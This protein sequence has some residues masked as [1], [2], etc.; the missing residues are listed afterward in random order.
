MVKCDIRKKITILGSTGSIGTQTLDIIND[1]S[2]RFECYAL[3][4]RS[5]WQ[6][7]AQQ[8]RKF[9]PKFVVIE[10]A[11]AFVYLKEELKDLPVE[12]MQGAE[13]IAEVAGLQDADIVV[14]ALVGYSGLLPTINAIN[15]GKR[16]AL[17][18]KETL[19]VGGELITSLLRNSKS[20][21]IPVDSE[22]SAIFQCLVG[23]DR[24][25]MHKIILTASGGPFRKLSANELEKVT[26]KDA[27]AHPNWNMG[28]KVTIDSASMMNK[29]FE[30]IEACWLFDCK[31]D[32]IEVVVHPQS[33]VH[34]MVEFCD[35]SIKAQ[36]GITDMHLPIRYALSYPE[37][38]E[39]SSDYLDITKIGTL[40][41]EK[42][43]YNKF[44][45]LK[46]AFQCMAA[47]G[48]APCILNAANE[49]AVE[50][51]LNS[52]IKF[53]DMPKVAEKVLE[54]MNVVSDCTLEHLV[55]TNAEARKKAVDI[56]NSIS[57]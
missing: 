1:Y 46:M 54:K 13:K 5:N 56:I 33:I 34:S 19:V 3:T 50:A 43:D 20:E 21:I 39:A 16:I 6:L 49:I 11:K 29:G 27:L 48:N 15:A 35:G 30:M 12:I 38:L 10:D 41:F 23:E 53:T 42:P 32:N 2:D 25:K 55:S 26:V 57:I 40:T 17:A 37:R 52:R 14:T 47:G 9:S 36:L 44:P 4:A 18:N 7:L 51:F 8:A 22:H 45:L 31:P 28:A 24:K